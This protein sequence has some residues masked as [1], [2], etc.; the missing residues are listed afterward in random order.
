M[1]KG[2]FVRFALPPLLWAAVLFTL[3]S[4]SLKG[5]PSVSG[6][7]KVVHFIVYGGLSFLCA[8]AFR[9]Y[10]A[11]AI[12]AALLGVVAASLYGASDEFHQSFTPGRSPDVWDW[13][14]DTLGA[15]A[16]VGAWYALGRRK[17]A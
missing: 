4:F 5:A 10:G 2:R 15:A 11:G 1:T 7:D 9:A 16:A 6:S 8:R 17:R 13:V 12:T 14:A 3:S